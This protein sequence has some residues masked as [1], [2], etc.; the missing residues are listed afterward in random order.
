MGKR[1]FGWLQSKLEGDN[2]GYLHIVLCL[3]WTCLWEHVVI[4]LSLHASGCISRLRSW[5]RRNLTC[6]DRLVPNPE[7]SWC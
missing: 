2:G 6:R 3:L 7:I 1:E 4:S 5:L